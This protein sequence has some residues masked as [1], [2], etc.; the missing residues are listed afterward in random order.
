MCF[1]IKQ[2]FFFFFVSFFV[3]DAGI[4][5]GVQ[6]MN[7]FFMSEYAPSAD[8]LRKKTFH[9]KPV[10]ANGRGLTSGKYA[11]IRKYSASYLAKIQQPRRG[12]VLQSLNGWMHRSSFPLNRDG[13]LAPSVVVDYWRLSGRIAAGLHMVH[14]QVRG[15]SFSHR[16]YFVSSNYY[17]QY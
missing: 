17:Y 16:A 14:R 6:R 15:I 8:Y 13:W 11:S 3:V 12:R 9:S 7:S 4:I 5:Q 2:V 1:L 10:L